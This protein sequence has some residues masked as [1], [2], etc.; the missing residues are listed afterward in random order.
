MTLT[1]QWEAAQLPLLLFGFKGELNMLTKQETQPSTSQDSAT[2]THY[3]V[4][5]LQGWAQ[6]IQLP[7]SQAKPTHT[8]QLLSLNADLL[9]GLRTTG[10]PQKS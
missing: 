6:G 5:S 3:S 1:P 10:S 2:A 4:L 7:P 8:A 9:P